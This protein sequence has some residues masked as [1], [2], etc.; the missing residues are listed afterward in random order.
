MVRE[1][2]LKLGP[3]AQSEV[4][5]SRLLWAIGFHQPPTYWLMCDG[6]ARC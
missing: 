4:V 5:A 1:W 3:E 2:S 6:R